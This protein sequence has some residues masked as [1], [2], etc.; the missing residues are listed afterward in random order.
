M[1][2]GLADRLHGQ[3][4]T[5]YLV[6]LNLSRLVLDMGGLQLAQKRSTPLVAA[7]TTIRLTLVPR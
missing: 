4:F 5:P 2:G 7:G 1:S 6:R 3:G